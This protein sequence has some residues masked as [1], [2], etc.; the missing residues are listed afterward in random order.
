MTRASALVEKLGI[1]TVTVLCGGFV[2]Q[3]KFTAKGLGLPNLPHAIHPGHVNLVDDEELERN[4]AGPMLQQVIDGLTIQPEEA[5]FSAEPDKRDIVFRGTFEEVNEHFLANEWS[6]GLP[7]VPPTIE[8][9]ERFLRFT[10]RSPDEVLGRLLPDSREA[11]IWNIAVNG[12]MSGCRPEYMPVLIAIVE[13]MVDPKFG[14][15]H[16]GHTP[17]TETLIIVNGRIIK[18]LEFNYAQAAL[19]PGFQANTSIGRF[20]RMYLRNACGFLPHKTD[21]GCFGGNFRIVLAENEDAVTSMG[22]QPHSVD[23]GYEAGDNLV[24][25]TSCTEMTQAIEVGDPSAEQILRN[26]EAR[27]AD[28]HMFIQFFFRG[29][30]TRPTVVITPAILKVLTDQGWTK[31][32]VREHFYEHAKLRVSRLSGMIVERFYKGIREGNW[33]EQLGTSMELERDIQMVSSPDDFIIV[34]AGDADRDHVEIGSGNG[35]IGFP[36]TKRIEVPKDW[37]NLLGSLRRR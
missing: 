9:V 7:I 15:E 3:G 27:M 10:D 16:L 35:Y 2:K 31:Q 22:W 25:I 11:T 33:P 32:A 4:V 34:V 6:E 28:N 24:T 21:K 12:V 8:A 36:V 30:V 37:A 14:H 26:I 18:E 5:G 19:R 23:E 1:P 29:M 20:W 13:A 17:G